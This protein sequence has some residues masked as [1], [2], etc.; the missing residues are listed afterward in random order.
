MLKVTVLNNKIF[1]HAICEESLKDVYISYTQFYNLIQNFANVIT[2][3]KAIQPDNPKN[4]KAREETIAKLYNKNKKTYLKIAT[5]KNYQPIQS[6]KDIQDSFEI[7]IENYEIIKNFVVNDFEKFE[8]YEELKKKL[9]Q[10]NANFSKI[11][12]LEDF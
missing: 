2:I 8:E 7:Q 12:E 3:K 4:Y 9:K 1:M 10:N 6:I 5:G 11:K